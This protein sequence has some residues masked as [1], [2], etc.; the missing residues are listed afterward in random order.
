M[1]EIYLYTSCDN[2]IGDFK[3]YDDDNYSESQLKLESDYDRDILQSI[4][5]LSNR[6]S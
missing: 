4:I 6:D 1:W 2:E 3:K 5:S